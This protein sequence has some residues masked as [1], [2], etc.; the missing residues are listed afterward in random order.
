M[1]L[2]MFIVSN[3]PRLVEVLVVGKAPNFGTG[4]LESRNYL[5]MNT[6]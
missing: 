1:L 6:W 2:A 3:N 5:K 4:L